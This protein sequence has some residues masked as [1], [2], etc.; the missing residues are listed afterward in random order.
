MGQHGSEYRK[1]LTRRVLLYGLLC[2]IAI[3][4]PPIIS[5]LNLK[6]VLKMSGNMRFELF[7][8]TMS[9]VLSAI[10][11]M[12]CRR[13][14]IFTLKAVLPTMIFFLV[15]FHF[16]IHFSE[17]SQR[18]GDYGCYQDAVNALSHGRNPYD[19]SECYL[20]PPFPA[21]V[22]VI[23]QSC[24]RWGEVYF[25]HVA[26]VD[27][28]DSSA[29]YNVFYV[30]QCVQFLLLLGMYLLCIRFVNGLGVGIIPASLLVATVFLC[31]NPLIRTLKYNQ[32]NLLVLDTMLVG[33]LA[34]ENR[35]RLSGAAVALGIHI[36][37]YPF[38]LVWQWL[39]TRRYQP[40]LWLCAGFMGLLLLQSQM[41]GGISGWGQFISFIND[42]PKTTFPRD[43][44][45]HSLLFNTFRH[46]ASL[47][48]ID[49]MTHKI[50]AGIAE[51]VIA[52]AILIWYLSR[53]RSR[54][55][56]YR[57]AFRDIAGSSFEI[58]HIATISRDYGHFTDTCG[59]I[60]LLSPLV[61]EHHYLLA[62]PL[63]LFSIVT[64]GDRKPWLVGIA[65][66]LILAI[67][68]FDVFPLSYNRLF[69]L[70][71]LLLATPPI[72]QIRK[73]WLSTLTI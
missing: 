58:R 10:W 70:L 62:L 18:S 28:A 69:G 60:L 21:Q 2:F 44:S 49:Y 14:R 30:Y 29:E 27:Q 57:S 64:F 56:S 67:P 6:I 61:W 7:G 36:K 3:V 13:I 43:N 63:I 65:S 47:L 9:M 54:E 39:I 15:A 48:R 16:L 25:F 33:F 55:H 31:N 24:V 34:M 51:W 40:I 41:P 38:V 32:M 5:R 45:L 73:G 72:V 59:I 26:S 12:E 19:S 71:T 66:L 42:F 8:M 23:A 53:C 22:M 1:I 37:L 17:Y 4:L 46:S 68:T 35:P 50:I 11:V 20:Y 52:V